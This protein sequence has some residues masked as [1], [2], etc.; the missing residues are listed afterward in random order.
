[1]ETAVKEIQQKQGP[2]SSDNFL[3]A[4]SAFGG[5]S[6]VGSGLGIFINVFV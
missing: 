6:D 5:S 2:P 3:G 1:L 4:F